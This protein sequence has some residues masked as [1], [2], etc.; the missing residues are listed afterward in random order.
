[1]ELK[2]C[3]AAFLVMPGNLSL[4]MRRNAL[5][6]SGYIL[7]S[8]TAEAEL[9]CPRFKTRMIGT[10]EMAQSVKLLACNKHRNLRSIR[11]THANNSNM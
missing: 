9:F 7:N 1:M 2:I 11:S 5:I 3:I 8:R 6:F 4:M 10:G